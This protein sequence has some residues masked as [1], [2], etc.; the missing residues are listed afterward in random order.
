MENG[1]ISVIVP[2]YNARKY[3]SECLDSLINQT[4]QN[5]EVILV[6]DGSVDDSLRICRKY[7][8][9]DER[10]HIVRFEK[11]QGLSA[12][13][14]AGIDTA[15][16][17][18]IY[19]LD[20][21]DYIRQD[22]L[23]IMYNA[24]LK[25]N[26]D[27]V[28]C[29]YHRVDEEG[30]LLSRHPLTDIEEGSPE[31]FY[32]LLAEEKCTCFMQTKLFRAD[33]FEKLRFP[34][35]KMYEDIFVMADILKACKTVT[36][37]G[38]CFFRYRIHSSAFTKQSFKIVHMDIVEAYIYM[39]CRMKESKSRYTW[40]IKYAAYVRLI[41]SIKR[42]GYSKE[43]QR[44]IRELRQELLR[45]C[46]FHIKYTPMTLVYDWEKQMKFSLKKRTI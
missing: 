12:A 13:R 5:L 19:F 15:A 34:V 42:S 46:G 30:R 24:M 41:D 43:E 11:N 22:M 40:Y 7:E 45:H 27:I 2:V 16:G 25:N 8:A 18:F 29:G 4:Y 38:E 17:E 32:Q 10:I 36:V 39:Y 9:C 21:D 20:S 37:L 44:R 3:L 28:L 31:T 26:A 33:L 14:N 6:D 35:G 1:L 23:E